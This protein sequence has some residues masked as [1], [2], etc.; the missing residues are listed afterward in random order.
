MEV[1]AAAAVEL[2]DFPL[3]ACVLFPL[4]EPSH[5]T[6]TEIS[7]ESLQYTGPYHTD[8]LLFSHLSL[9]LAES[10]GVPQAS[11]SSLLYLLDL[12]SPT[13]SL[14]T[15]LDLWILNYTGLLI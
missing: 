9:L 1:E 8:K 3:P 10:S 13:T 6:K 5:L 7:I 4:P 14:S 12:H 2:V 11:L 15:S